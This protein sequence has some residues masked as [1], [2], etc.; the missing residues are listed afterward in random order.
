MNH[1]NGAQ[2]Q[3]WR[4][5]RRS[6]NQQP[7]LAGCP[8]ARELQP[9]LRG[10]ANNVIN[11]RANAAGLQAMQIRPS[12][13]DAKVPTGPRPLSGRPDVQLAGARAR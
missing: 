13:V 3:S 10:P 12:G 7:R 1:C 4:A 9:E 8:A 5:Q 11:W 2:T 6:F